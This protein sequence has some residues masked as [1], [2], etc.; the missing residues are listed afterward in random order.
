MIGAASPEELQ[1]QVATASGRVVHVGPE[2]IVSKLDIAKQAS[3]L[4]T[5]GLDQRIVHQ[6][7]VRG[8]LAGQAE[9]LRIH[10]QEKRTAMQQALAREVGDLLACATPRGGFFIW[11]TL[12]RSVD[13]D[14]LLARAME[15]AVTYVAGSAF[16]VDG[17][18]ANTMRLSFSH[19]TA[20]RIQE[21]IARLA[22]ALRG[23]MEQ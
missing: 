5:G 7:I 15:A 6:A 12:P 10:Y 20:D 16:F 13:A 8:V 19:P 3:D 14:R 1:A 17:S 18:H 2:P 21:G 9:R 11:A 22:G 23:E 4:C